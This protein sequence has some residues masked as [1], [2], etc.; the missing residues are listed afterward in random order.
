MFLVS[1]SL[2]VAA[3]PEGLP[4]IVTLTL[5]IGVQQMAGKNAIVK[6]LKSVETLGSATVVCT[7][8]TGT[9]TKNEMT[10]RELFFDNRF[11]QVTGAGYSPAGDFLEDENAVDLS[12]DAV[13][14]KLLESAVLCNSAFVD[15]EGR[16]VKPIGDPTE[17][18]LLVCGKKAGLT[19]VLEKV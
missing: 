17:V 10:V 15:F 19:R 12:K 2:A 7:D 4:A 14:Q 13:F 18:A 1:V 9:L 3:I 8:K 11:I 5:A 16:E 6:K